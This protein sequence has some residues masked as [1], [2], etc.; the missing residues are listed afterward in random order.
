MIQSW[1]TTSNLAMM[2]GSVSCRACSN[3]FLA[4]SF[5]T[6]DL[7]QE[8][9]IIYAMP[10]YHAYTFSPGLAILVWPI[11]FLRCLEDLAIQPQGLQVRLQ[12]GATPARHRILGGESYS[13]LKRAVGSS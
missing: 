13:L 4:L 10:S 11:E 2:T 3:S 7:V 5:S 1:P 6:R 9:A 8:N 12:Q